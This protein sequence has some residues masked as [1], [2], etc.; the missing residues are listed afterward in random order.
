MAAAEDIRT[1]D[2]KER[3]VV[4]AL[5]RSASAEYL[6]EYLAE[7]GATSVAVEPR[8]V[9][10]HFLHDF[11]TYYS[12]VFSPCAA[13]CERWHFFKGRKGRA[14]RQTL[15]ESHDSEVALIRAEARLQSGYLGFA[16][17]R[18][19]PAA[20]M[21]RTVLS[22]YSDDG[23]Q[24]NY[25]VVRDYG[26]HLQ[27]LRLRIDGLAYQEQDGGAAVCASTALWTAFQK[28]A[29]DSGNRTP[30]PTSVTNA[31]ASPFP[32]SHGL[33]DPDMARAISQLGY[34][35]DRFA[36]GSEAEFKA[37]VVATL[38]SGLPVVLLL[39]GPIDPTADVVGSLGHAVTLT[40][41]RGDAAAVAT[42][43]GAPVQLVGGGVATFYAH[44]DN[45]GSHAHFEIQDVSVVDGGQRA[46]MVG[47]LRG[48][49]VQG[50]RSWW[51]P[52]RW[53]IDG[54]LVPK[55]LKV[56]LPIEQLFKLLVEAQDLFETLLSS[57]RGTPV[58]VN[59]FTYACYYDRGVG[60]QRR[61]TGDRF[62]TAACR[63]F[64]RS[65]SLPRHAAV[66]ELSRAGTQI[67]SLVYDAT[68]LADHQA[69]PLVVLT[70]G[71]PVGAEEHSVFDAVVSQLW[72]ES[73]LIAGT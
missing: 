9:D 69:A 56:R 3:T 25:A 45:L 33:D 59:E 66:I 17:R 32:A 52:D 20:A 2:F 16:V 62:A 15:T 71:A 26:V 34:T 12:R 31:A 37:H 55:P 42:L 24:R 47:V 19:L 18:P 57:L 29:Y 64:H 14:L 22:T 73:H 67:A 44:D 5:G 65:C 46:D 58:Q 6:V 39:R 54:A 43:G 40:G 51:T 41:F 50:T 7:L 8:Y 4:D 38:R 60:V 11:A 36:P 10:R 61:I 13:H 49:S 68:T 35:A 23:G 53:V 72:T 28:V 70:P 48:R 30:T 63:K 21:G 1:L 27:G